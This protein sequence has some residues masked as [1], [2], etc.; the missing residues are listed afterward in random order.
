MS[1]L[2]Q[3]GYVRRAI[4]KVGEGAMA[5]RGVSAC[6][7]A[8]ALLAAIPKFVAQGSVP[9]AIR[10][11]Q[12]AAICMAFTSAT[13]VNSLTASASL[14]CDEPMIDSNGEP[15]DVHPQLAKGKALGGFRSAGQLGRAIGPLIGEFTLS[16][17][18]STRY[19]TMLPSLRF[20]LD[21]WPIDNLRHR[22]S[23]HVSAIC[24]HAKPDGGEVETGV[25]RVSH[26]QIC[27]SYHIVNNNL[28]Q[29]VV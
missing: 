6:T 29:W 1:A 8:L 28:I 21:T 7:I 5:R 24:S 16:P 12:A 14:Q 25:S 10:C 22:G 13:V 23:A 4:S 26:I 19:L 2:L 15:K 17:L 11:L 9:T 18:T 3:G 27:I 20:L